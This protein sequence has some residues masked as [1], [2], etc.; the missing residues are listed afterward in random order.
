MLAATVCGDP[1]HDDLARPKSAAEFH[2]Q[3]AYDPV[4][5]HRI[6]AVG[7]LGK[8]AFTALI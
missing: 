6:S 8:I 7:R 1:G 2:C 3:S 5:T 4:K